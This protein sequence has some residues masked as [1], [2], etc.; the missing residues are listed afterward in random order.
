MLLRRREVKAAGQHALGLSPAMAPAKWHLLNQLQGHVQPGPLL[1]PSA[2]H[3]REGGVGRQTEGRG[4]GIQS[5][6]A[7]VVFTYQCPVPF[8]SACTPNSGWV[9]VQ[10]D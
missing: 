7:G 10:K 2:R 1:G 5:L 8:S 9:H 4:G 6:R 3:L